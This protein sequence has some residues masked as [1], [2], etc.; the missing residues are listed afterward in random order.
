MTELLEQ[1][2]VGIAQGI[3]HDDCYFCNGTIEPTTEANDFL[4]TPDED[5]AEME[6]SLGEYKFKND[7][8]KLGT[9]LGGKPN[10]IVV[11]LGGKKYDA[12]VAAHHL[13]PGN[14]A[15]KDSQLMKGKFLGVDKTAKGNIGY[16]VNAAPNGVWLPGNYG[17][18]PWGTD[19]KDFEKQAKGVK[20]KDFAFAAMDA[21]QC[22]FHDAHTSY[23]EFVASILDKIADKL[24]KNQTLWCPEQKKK[25]KEEPPQMFQIVGRLNSV[26]SRMRR[27]L[28][29]PTS[30]WH[31]NVYTSRFAEQYM[32]EKSAQN[33]QPSTKKKK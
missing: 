12:A 11:T 21:W 8:G 16:N 32:T 19:G 7:A 27:M 17:V 22:Q 31:Q 18:R 13:I 5:A 33:K 3:N 10:P 1:V 28:V 9:A 20:A 14:A 26:S 24:R 23:S 29:F 30:N 4:D 25:S 6:D 15:L 2:A